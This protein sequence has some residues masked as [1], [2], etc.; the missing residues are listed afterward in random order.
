MVF[1]VQFLLAHA[2]TLGGISMQE[3]L[4]YLG[5]KSM[6]KSLGTGK[7][8]QLIDL[9]LPTN[10]FKF[11]RPCDLAGKDFHPSQKYSLVY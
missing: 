5:Q 10:A 9:L 7:G 1:K 11:S 8:Y 2:H 3:M 6:E 4:S